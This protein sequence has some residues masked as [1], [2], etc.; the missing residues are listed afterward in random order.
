MNMEKKKYEL[1]FVKRGT[2]IIDAGLLNYR[3]EGRFRFTCA[4]ELAHWLI[5]QNLFSG[6]GN[7]AAMDKRISKSSE[8]D[9]YIERQADI[10]GSALLMPIG[11]VKRC[12]YRLQGENK[13]EILAKM[14]CVSRQAME[15]RLR[16]RCLV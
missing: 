3:S 9:K 12:F 1:V 16:E 14:F 6:S 2:I 7:M 5:H 13:V 10:L 11:Q 4:H 15:I 8:V